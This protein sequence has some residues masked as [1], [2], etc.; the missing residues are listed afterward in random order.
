MRQPVFV[1]LL[2]VLILALPALV[3][4]Q[5]DDYVTVV[6]YEDSTAR[7]AQLYNEELLTRSSESNTLE[8]ECDA[9][10]G[11]G[12][13]WTAIN[14]RYVNLRE[15]FY[16]SSVNPCTGVNEYRNGTKIACQGTCCGAFADG[17]DAGYMCTGD[18]CATFATGHRAGALCR[19][20]DARGRST[21]DAHAYG[22]GDWV[23]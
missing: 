3:N 18:Y 10:T 2:A 16:D 17:Y 21:T 9:A 19:G 20:T 7:L 11:S 4:G 14:A 1:R 6:G 22:L 23:V 12:A 13:V 15:T 8:A 5:L